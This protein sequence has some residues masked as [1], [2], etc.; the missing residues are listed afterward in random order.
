MNLDTYIGSY[1]H[2]HDEDAEEFCWSPNFTL[3]SNAPPVTQSS[4]SS[5]ALFFT[6]TALPFPKVSHESHIRCLRCWLFS[7]ST[8]HL[9][10][11]FLCVAVVCLSYRSAVFLRVTI[12]QSFILLPI[13]VYVLTRL[14]LYK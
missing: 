10:F 8:M 4:R 12:S 3:E 5:T 7:L 13:L 14:C 6:P 9:R 11:F 2:L 1:N